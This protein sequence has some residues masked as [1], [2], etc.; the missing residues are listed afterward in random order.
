[1]VSIT[2]NKDDSDRIVVTF[3]YN[4]LNISRKGDDKE[5]E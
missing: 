4:P 5:E 2:I 3:S 1:M